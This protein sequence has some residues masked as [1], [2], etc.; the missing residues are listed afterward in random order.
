MKKMDFILSVLSVGLALAGF[1]TS[2]W[3]LLLCGALTW[4]FLVYK[5]IRRDALA[6]RS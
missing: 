1:L 4:S 5:E 3:W 2:K 6:P